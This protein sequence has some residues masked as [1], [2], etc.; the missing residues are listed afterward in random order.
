MIC[1]IS[2]NQLDWVQLIPEVDISASQ[3]AP[4]RQQCGERHVDGLLVD[5][6]VSGECWAFFTA[7][8]K[9]HRRLV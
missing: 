5:D 6:E 9:G 8:D 3:E 2:E 4:A 1:A 7:K